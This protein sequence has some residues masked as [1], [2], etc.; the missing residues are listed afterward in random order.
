MGAA[1]V[2]FGAAKLLAQIFLVIWQLM[3]LGQSDIAARGVWLLALYMPAIAIVSLGLGLLLVAVLTRKGGQPLV[4]RL[5]LGAVGSVIGTLAIFKGADP[6]S[7][8]LNL[9][10]WAS[11]LAYYSVSAVVAAALIILG[12]VA[13][14]P[15]GRAAEGRAVAA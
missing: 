7:L 10:P 13:A 5:T 2:G 14:I 6:I 4:E 12:C 15:L 3:S 1:L 9:I 11:P 8:V